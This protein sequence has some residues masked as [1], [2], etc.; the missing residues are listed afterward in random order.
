MS[1]YTEDMQMLAIEMFDKPLNDLNIAQYEMV[2]N[3]WFKMKNM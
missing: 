2:Y 1:K 3:E